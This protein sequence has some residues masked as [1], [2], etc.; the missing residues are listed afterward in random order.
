[1]RRSEFALEIKRIVW[2]LFSVALLIAV[3]SGANVVSCSGAELTKVYAGYGGIAGYQLPLWVNKEADISK[4][5]R[6]DLQPL[7]ISG[8][9]LGMQALLANSIQISQNSASAA[10]SAPLRGAPPG[11]IAPLANRMSAPAV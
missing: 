4:K 8:G 2:R 3:I 1:M 6:I 9:A 7:L 10:G 11:L 5:Y